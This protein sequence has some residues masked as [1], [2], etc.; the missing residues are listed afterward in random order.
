M[1]GVGCPFHDAE[2]ER[3]VISQKGNASLAQRRLHIDEIADNAGA[4]RTAVDIVAK[5]NKR[6]RPLAG[7]LPT[8]LDQ[9][10]QLAQRAMDVT[11]GVGKRHGAQMGFSELK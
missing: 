6:D 11:D 5:K 9:A 3:L 1:I 8:A 7:V 2:R 10:A 4:F